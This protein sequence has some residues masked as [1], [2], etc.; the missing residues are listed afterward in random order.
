MLLEIII[1]IHAE[2]VRRFGKFSGQVAYSYLF[3]FAL[4]SLG[5][6]STSIKL[7]KDCL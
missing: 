1:I 4:T 6:L 7:I 3:S 5:L 2:D